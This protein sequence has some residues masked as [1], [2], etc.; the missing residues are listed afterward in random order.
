[1]ISKDAFEERLKARNK[2]KDN[3]KNLFIKFCMLC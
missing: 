3:F 2:K 1:V